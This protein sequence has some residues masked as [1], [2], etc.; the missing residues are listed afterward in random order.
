MTGAVDEIIQ[1]KNKSY[2]I[3]DYKT[4]KYTENQD[5]LLPLY[6]VQLNSYALIA[7]NIGLSP[8]SGI[9]LLYYEPITGIVQSGLEEV[10]LENGFSMGFEAHLLAVDLQGEKLIKPLL[11]KVR[12]IWEMDSP[13]KSA[14]R[15]RDCQ[16]LKEL[17]GMVEG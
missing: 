11:R 15:C 6:V 2:F 13:P 12:E 10:L 14:K 1:L 16:L 8:V 7:Q 17:V 3:I 5:A 4:A 9:G